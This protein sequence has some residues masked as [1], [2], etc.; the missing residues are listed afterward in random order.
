LKKLV[1]TSILLV[2]VMVLSMFGAP[3]VTNAATSL[4]NGADV[5]W[6]PEIERGGSKFYDARGRKIDPLVL[7]KQSG[8]KVAR[9][10]LWVQPPDRRSSINEV[11]ALAKRIKKA[12]LVFALDFHYSDWWADPANQTTPISWQGLN[13][14][15]LEQKIN[16]YTANTLARFALQKT[17]PQWVQ[18]GNEIANGMLWPSGK[19]NTWSNEEFKRLTGLLNSASSAVRASA[20]KP[21]VMIHLETGGDSTKTKT[22]LTMALANGLTAP[23]AIGLSYYSQWGGPLTNLEKTISVVT[24]DFN[25][26]VAIA[27]TAYP[28][29]RTSPTKQVLDAT[30]APL[31]GF[32]ISPSGQSAYATK[33]CAVLRSKAGSK[34]VGVWWWEGFSP[35]KAKLQ[36][37]LGPSYV[38]SSSLVTLAGRANKAM[39]ALGKCK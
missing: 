10:R 5:S 27:E 22:W 21:K 17:S 8:L 39:L 12:G 11:L 13:Q 34:S 20:G 18:V 6:L 31:P 35:N 36:D 24:D 7:M 9:V 23:D 4:S 33:S 1:P 25:L 16:E 30:K 26:N 38:S 32:S 2:F 3:A 19:L 37:E 14:T 28:N 15:Q 29:T